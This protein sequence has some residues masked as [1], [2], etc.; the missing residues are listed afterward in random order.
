MAQNFLSYCVLV[1][2]QCTTCILAA[3]EFNE[4]EI[5]VDLR[6][7]ISKEISNFLMCF[8][9]FSLRVIKYLSTDYNALFDFVYQ[10]YS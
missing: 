4:C 8:S 7:M 2:L 9:G 1:S 5:Y 3:L 10:A 6:S